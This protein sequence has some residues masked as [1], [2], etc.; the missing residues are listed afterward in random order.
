MAA[1]S[2]GG[3]GPWREGVDTLLPAAV[4]VLGLQAWRAGLTFL[5]GGGVVGLLAAVVFL[6]VPA[7]RLLGHLLGARRAA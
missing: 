4:L 2:E 7:A 5:P 3:H 1:E 6:A